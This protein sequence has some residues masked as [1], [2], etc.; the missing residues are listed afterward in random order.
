MSISS[1]KLKY[2]DHQYLY[3]LQTPEYFGTSI[4][5]IGMTEQKFIKRFKQYP[6]GTKLMSHTNVSNAKSLEKEFISRVKNKFEIHHGNEWFIS[7]ESTLCNILKDIKSEDDAKYKCDMCY[8]SGKIYAFNYLLI[9]CNFC[10][11]GETNY[12]KI[13]NLY[14]NVYAFKYNVDFNDNLITK[15]IDEINIQAS[16]YTEFDRDIINHLIK[17]NTKHVR[18]VKLM[19]K[20]ICGKMCRKFS[21][22]LSINST[23]SRKK[24][25]EGSGYIKIYIKNHIFVILKLL[26]KEVKMTTKYIDLMMDNIDI[27]IQKGDKLNGGVITEQIIINLLFGYNINHSLFNKL[28]TFMK[29]ANEIDELLKLLIRKYSVTYYIYANTYNIKNIHGFLYILMTEKENLIMSMLYNMLTIVLPESLVGLCYDYIHIFT[30]HAVIDVDLEYCLS[31][32]SKKITKEIDH[33]IE[34]CYKKV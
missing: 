3:V 34:I 10:K 7:D 28:D 22:N 20:I 31:N 9:I 12:D 8:D 14:K 32:Y 5:K 33:T 4:N 24:F 18:P 19:D 16:I 23:K 29:F 30:T 25:Y 11:I 26:A 2:H 15:V 17:C 1:K 27:I 21:R 13:I 6:K